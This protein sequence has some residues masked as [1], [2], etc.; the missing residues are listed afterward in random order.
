MVAGTLVPSAFHFITNSISL[1]L[2]CLPAICSNGIG[3]NMDKKRLVKRV[4]NAKTVKALDPVAGLKWSSLFNHDSRLH[5]ML[6]ISR[7]R[8]EEGWSS[9]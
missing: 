8:Q 3:V 7:G 9:R 5:Q 4:Q 1:L 6:K 2:I